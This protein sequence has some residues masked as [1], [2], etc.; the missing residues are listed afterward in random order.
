[1]KNDGRENTRFAKSTLT[2]KPLPASQKIY[3]KGSLHNLRVPMREITLSTLA[4]QPVN[5]EKTSLLTYDTSGPYTDQK[6]EVDIRRGLPPLRHAWVHDHKDVDQLSEFTSEFSLKNSGK[7]NGKQYPLLRKPLR[8]RTKM[9]VSQ[10]H[11][12]RQGIITP[13]MEYIAIRENQ[14]C[15]LTSNI[16]TSVLQQHPGKSWELE[17][18]NTLHQSL[19]ETRWPVEEPSSRPISTTR[20]SNR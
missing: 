17:S 9:N 7:S 15:D 1:M 11:Y 18:Q 2:T 12:A 4:N 19:F 3:V 5:G 10:M 16:G 6:A 14:V 13:E 20:K 8:A